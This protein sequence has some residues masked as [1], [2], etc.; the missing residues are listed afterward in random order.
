VEYKDEG[1]KASSVWKTAQLETRDK[2]TVFFGGN[3]AEIRIQTDIASDR[4]LLILKD[5][6][7]NCFVP[8]LIPYFAYII[9]IDPRYYS[10]D[11]NLVMEVEKVTDV[12]FL[13]NA[14]TFATDTALQRVIKD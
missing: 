6:Y 3:H 9:L 12:L 11:L 1:E 14:A 10:G 7:A 5:S 8:F 4:I 13:Y 2:Y